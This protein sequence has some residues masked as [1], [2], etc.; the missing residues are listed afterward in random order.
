M[1]FQYILL[2]ISVVAMLAFIWFERRNIQVQGI[3]PLLYF[4]MWRTRRGLKL[5]DWLASAMP[6]FWSVFFGLGIVAGFLGMLFIS[7]ELVKTTVMLFLAPGAAPGIQ[8]VLPFEAK[9]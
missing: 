6:G 3:F 8:P 7:Y 5:M 9:G 2:G 4:A 1:D